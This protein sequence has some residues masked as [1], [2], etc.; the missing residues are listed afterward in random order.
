MQI[1]EYLPF[2]KIST[3]SISG[4][5][6][7]AAAVSIPAPFAIAKPGYQSAAD[8]QGLI[9]DRTLIGEQPAFL[10]APTER[11]TLN[12]SESALHIIDNQY[13]AL[14][15][16]SSG[17]NKKI[18]VRMDKLRR[19]IANNRAMQALLQSPLTSE[20]IKSALQ[21]TILFI[22]I[23]AMGENGYNEFNAL[24]LP[25]ARRTGMPNGKFSNLF[26]RSGNVNTAPKSKSLPE[27]QS[28]QS[29][30]SPKTNP[31]LGFFSEV[32][33]PNSSPTPS[34]AA[35]PGKFGMGRRAAPLRDLSAF[36]ALSDDSRQAALYVFGSIPENSDP[37]MPFN[38][39]VE[40]KRY[41]P[42]AGTSKVDYN[43]SAEINTLL[44]KASLG[45]AGG[46]QTQAGGYFCNVYP[47]TLPDPG[48]Q[49]D[50]LISYWMNNSIALTHGI[51]IAKRN[52]APASGVSIADS[53]I[54]IPMTRI[55]YFQKDY[56]YELL[57]STYVGERI[58]QFTL[59]RK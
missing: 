42:S 10:R 58:S 40:A 56:R 8:A 33:P 20:K 52:A 59:R 47:L 1:F 43:T 19:A 13:L 15:Y 16:L 44:D 50:I 54:T 53:L 39:T 28:D 27:I 34:P 7:M 11:I 55:Q 3:L 12:T 46:N 21:N 24:S 5:L 32:Q 6:L 31:N 17:E 4:L 38:F 48:G 37:S 9:A 36:I 26:N 25:G 2:R 22:S 29:K 45:T 57:K 51:A 35:P 49:F 14:P 30:N 41:A 18:Y 23:P